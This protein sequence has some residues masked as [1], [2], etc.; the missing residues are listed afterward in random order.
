M[1]DNSQTII[2]QMM[3]ARGYEITESESDKMV[4]TKEDHNILIISVPDAKLNTNTV[5]LIITILQTNELDHAIVIYND[6]ITSGA[7]KI[8]E[9]IYT[10]DKITIECFDRSELQ[11]N[12][13]THRLQSQFE[14]S[15]P[16]EYAEIK[17]KWGTNLPIML[18][19]DPISRFYNFARG[20]IIKVT[21]K[22]GFVTYKIVK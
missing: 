22:N 1:A 11:Y 3:E 6:T 12:I 19:T 16:E 2:T 10:S 20:D 5:K 14:K 15:S 13:T 4:A 9:T 7:K 21:R 8:I 18:K 17:S